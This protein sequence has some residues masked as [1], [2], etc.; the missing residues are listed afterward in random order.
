MFRNIE[1]DDWISARL[2]VQTALE[3]DPQSHWL[4]T[5]LAF[6]YYEQFAYQRELDL[7]RHAPTIE[8]QCPLALWDHA[9]ALDMLGRPQE[10][11]TF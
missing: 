6:T 4:L 1:N 7:S 3:K 2:L 5:H 11:L 9:G 10:A 8:P